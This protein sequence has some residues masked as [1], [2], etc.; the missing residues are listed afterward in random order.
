[1]SLYNR[2][3]SWYEVVNVPKNLRHIIKKRQIWVSLHTSEKTIAKIRSA[4]ILSKINQQF[5]IERQKMA[6]FNDGD[7]PRLKVFYEYLAT[8]DGY[9]EYKDVDIESCALDFC[10][11]KTNKDLAI[12]NRDIQTLNYYQF[13]L[14]DYISAYKTNDYTKAKDAVDAY[15]IANKMPKPTENCYPK[16]LKA[17]MLAYIQHL[18]LAINYLKGVELKQPNKIISVLPS[19]ETQ[20]IPYTPAQSMQS[21]RKPD[22]NLAE[23]GEIYNNE[24]SRDNVSQAQKDKIN[25]RLYVLNQLLQ[26]KTIRQITPDDLQRLVYDVQWIPLRLGKNNKDV[27]M[28]AA[29]KR[30]RE[31]PEKSISPKTRGDY[32]QTLKSIYAWAL[33]RKY[34]NENIMDQIDVPAIQI[35]KT[36][37]KYIPFTVQQMNVL[38]HSDLFSRHWDDNPQKRS[39]FWISL[40][41][42][43][44]GA[45][46]NEI[47][48]L[49]FDDVME[50]EGVAYISINENNGKHVKT[51]AGI[52][53]VPLHN[54]LLR[55]AFLEFVAKMKKIAPRRKVNKRI[56]FTLKPNTRGE[57][58]AQPSKWFLKLLV[59][60]K[61]KQ[62]GL[63]FH[64]WRHTVRTILRNNNCPIDRVQL[65]QGWEG[66]NSLSEHY[67]TISIKVLADELN[68]KLI[69]KGLDLS[70]LYI[71]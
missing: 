32:L 40:L 21:Y 17:F 1:M 2:G 59:E 53:R 45:R 16:F 60:L 20:A 71:K 3:T 69:Y 7:A 33:K 62:K 37:E 5:I 4:M 68:E 18:E 58:S 19:V 55:I 25:H 22:L 27:D 70:H 36:E 44:T 8:P 34:I 47:C 42:A 31:H 57:Y 35:S 14:N 65:I 67:G 29:V 13:L 24:A 52:R 56:F 46:L 66:A 54:E 39:M 64:S 49:E 51:K 23:L 43:Y 61:I 26:G 50:D 10:I 41:G 38:F 12:V 28:I 15:I 48:Q 11:N 30:N 6:V 63:C 9:L